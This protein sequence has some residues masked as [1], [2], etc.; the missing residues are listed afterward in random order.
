MGRGGLL[1]STILKELLRKSVCPAYVII[2]NVNTQYPNLTR[3]ICEKNNI[4]YCIPESINSSET[5]QT[6]KNIDHEYVIVASLGVIIKKK[7]LAC[8]NFFNVH[9]GVLP[10]YKGAHPNFWKIKNGDD[11]YGV[12]IHQMVERVDSGRIVL[13]HEKDYSEI[14]NGYD[15]AIHTFIDAGNALYKCLKGNLF[16]N[17]SSFTSQISSGTYYRKFNEN[18]FEIDR[19]LPVRT[20][21]KIINRIQY[22]GKP[23][24]ILNNKRLNIYAANLLLDVNSY[25][26]RSNYYRINEDTIIAQAK[27]GIMELKYVE[28]DS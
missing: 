15:L 20:N 24:I 11:V 4:D 18:D 17:H 16:N 21:Y 10:D 27:D 25:S 22:Y 2:E 19:A 13:I 26:D 9:A 12:T 3:I 1:T 23:F 5:I 7:I 14:I 28:Y 6:I 8:S